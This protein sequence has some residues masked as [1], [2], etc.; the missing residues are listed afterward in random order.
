MPVPFPALYLYPL[1]G[2][3]HFSPFQIFIRD[4]KSYNGTFING[5]RLSQEGLESEP[6]GLKS[7]DIG[8]L[9]I[10]IVGGDNKTIVY[11]KVA[12]RVVCIFSEQDALVEK[13][14]HRQ[15]SL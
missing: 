4:L 5:E 11:H 6:F 7:N 9:G 1:N 2:C 8:E 10:D 15:S 13:L 3:S 14:P 12:A